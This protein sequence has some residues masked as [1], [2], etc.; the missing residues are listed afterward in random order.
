[1][2]SRSM[3]YPDAVHSP[4]PTLP[5]R[6]LLPQEYRDQL[7][8]HRHAGRFFG[9]MAAKRAGDALIARRKFKRVSFT[10]HNSCLGRAGY[11]ADNMLSVRQGVSYTYFGI[12]LYSLCFVLTSDMVRSLSPLAK[13]PRKTKPENGGCEPMLLTP[14][15]RMGTALLRRTDAKKY[16]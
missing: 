13:I 16:G 7:F 4:P 8:V 14:R 11:L 12:T 9:R 1:M 15:V 3:Q 2:L 6:Q 10:L 5:T